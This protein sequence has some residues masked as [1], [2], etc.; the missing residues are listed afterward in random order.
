MTIEFGL[1]LPFGPP[2]HNTDRFLT[3]LDD[4]LPV[5]QGHFHSLWMTD[6]FQWEDKPTYEAWTVMAY[7]AARWPG[8][9]I[10]PMVLGQSYRNPAM[11]AKMGATLQ[12]L[13]K[14]NFIMALGAGW[15]EDEYRGYNFPFP[16]PGVRVE[17]LE[18][19][20]EIIKRMWTEPGQVSFSGKHYSVVNAYCEPKPDPLPPII[21]GTGGTKAMLLAA[22]YAD[23]WNRSDANFAEYKTK[24]DVLHQHCRTI[25][26]DPAS[27]RKTWFGRL[28]LG[29]THDEALQRGSGRWTPDNAFVGTTREVTDSLKQFIDVGCDY[30]M[31]EVLDVDRPDVQGMLLNDVLPKLG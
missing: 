18:D 14:G 19:T 15:K 8:W 29:R 6:H 1:S 27:I 31:V 22:K 28:S 23:W 10:G 3:A 4:V 26:R 9:K 16:S 5:L 11:L 7:L 2:A 13:S 25:G 12:A 30:F 21:V 20:L 24:V 17:Q